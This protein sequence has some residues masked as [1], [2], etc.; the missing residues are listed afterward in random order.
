M[1]VRGGWER[2][3]GNTVQHSFP[4]GK[5]ARLALLPFTWLIAFATVVGVLKVV[6]SI[7]GVTIPLLLRTNTLW[8]LALILP[9]FIFGMVV[10][11]I[12]M[13]LVAYATPLRRLFERECE[14][15][16]RHDFADAMAALSRVALVLFVVVIIGSALFLKYGP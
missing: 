1:I 3:S 13:N 8:P 15:T 14:E 12:G 10:G 16:G 2:I 7:R 5:K 4:S 11:L 6:A 9:A